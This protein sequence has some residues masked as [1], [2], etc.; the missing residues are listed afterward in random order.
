MVADALANRD[1]LSR[2]PHQPSRTSLRWRHG[3]V[4]GVDADRL[5]TFV[6]VAIGWLFGVDHAKRP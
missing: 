1:Q 4:Q 5:G 2:P 3:A 6:L